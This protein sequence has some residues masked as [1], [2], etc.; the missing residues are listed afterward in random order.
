MLEA[1]HQV[2]IGLL[3][4]LMCINTVFSACS[5]FQKDCNTRLADGEKDWDAGTA[6]STN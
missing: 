5:N 1:A 6:R 4:C 3:E 2:E